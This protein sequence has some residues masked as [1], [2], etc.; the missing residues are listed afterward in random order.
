V[1]ACPFLYRNYRE[2]LDELLKQGGVIEGTPPNVKPEQIISTS[3]ALFIEPSGEF[4]VKATYEKL[5]GAEFRNI[6]YLMP[7]R[8]VNTFNLSSICD[9]IVKNLLKEDVFGYV[10]V[11]LLIFP[12]PLVKSSFPLF[13]LIGLDCFMNDFTSILYYFEFLVKGKS[14]PF[15]G[16]HYAEQISQ[17]IDNNATNNILECK[18]FMTF[19]NLSIILKLVKKIQKPR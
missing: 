9:G 14:D 7:N 17:I 3:V 10:T 8:N 1:M 4:Q 11:D 12:D 19:I 13:W 15:N 18:Y 16:R 2:Y 5:C 6:G